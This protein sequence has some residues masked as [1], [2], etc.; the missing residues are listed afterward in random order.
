[1]RRGG[2]HQ[3]GAGRWV[4]KPAVS[5]GAER[6]YRDAT[7]GDLDA[8]VDECDALVQPY[9]PAIEE[10]GEL[11]IVCIAGT[12]MHAVAKIPAAGDW[13]TQE[14]HG[15]AVEPVA[16]TDR[17]GDLARAALAVAPE[18]PVYARVDV[19]GGEVM[20][21]ELIEPTLWFEHSAATTPALA[22]EL[23]TAAGQ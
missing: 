19:V 21:L 8:L 23:A 9:R 11:S 22:D 17:L 16:I 20:E 4:V 5:I 3:L 7:Q 2:T 6:T 10:A 15:A 18:P 13:R 1:V 12:P 14:H